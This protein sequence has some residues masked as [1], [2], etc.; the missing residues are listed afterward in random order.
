MEEKRRKASIVEIVILILIAILLFAIFPP[1]SP[2]PIVYAIVK[3]KR[4][5]ED[6]D[7]Y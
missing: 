6:P 3:I 4:Y 5:Y 2:V 7:N 1:A